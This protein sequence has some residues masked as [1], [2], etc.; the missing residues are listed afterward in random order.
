MTLATAIARTTRS[1]TGVETLINTGLA[2][3]EETYLVVQFQPTGGSIETLVRG[4]HY[5]T[6]KV[7]SSLTAGPVDFIP[8]SSMPT[9]PGVLTFTRDTPAV[10]PLSL[11][12]GNFDPKV[13]EKALDEGAARDAEQRQTTGDVP[14]LVTR[15]NALEAAVASLGTV[16][17][18]LLASEAEADAAIIDTKAVTPLT[19]KR[20]AENAARGFVLQNGT[21]GFTAPVA[22]QDPAAPTHLMTLQAADARFNRRVK[23]LA[24]RT[25]FVRSDGN[26]ANTGLVDSAGGAFLTV[27]KAQDVIYNDLDLNGFNVEIDL[28]SG[29]LAPAAILFN[30][31]QVGAGRVILRPRNGL[32]SSSFPGIRAS[33]SGVV[34]EISWPLAS[35]IQAANNADI[36]TAEN[37]AVVV[38]SGASSLSLTHGF[39]SGNHL[40][41]QD[42]GVIIRQGGIINFGGGGIAALVAR[43]NGT[44]NIQGG[45]GLTFANSWTQGLFQATQGG[46]INL[47]GIGLSG[48][49]F[50]ATVATAI[51][52]MGGIINAGP[53][54]MTGTG[55][56]TRH[57]ATLNGVINSNGGGASMFAGTVAGTVAT[58]GQFA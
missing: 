12:T 47:Q 56:G 35:T 34:I 51:A 24:N 30:R 3:T 44:I 53:A 28:S 11:N 25:Y 20:V 39:A 48:S 36:I 58:G 21:R 26:D 52:S 17:T 14:G 5:I 38:L 1:W 9:A 29:T 33:G 7:G 50:T 45:Q 6:Q 2:V 37:G 13:L 8:L 32:N 16:G 40:V 42:G 18:L 27:A 31:P 49:T 55:T 41:A 43:R 23:L 22:G 15:L 4:L 46:V 54:A 10:Q 19:A 57:S